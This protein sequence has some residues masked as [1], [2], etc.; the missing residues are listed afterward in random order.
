MDHEEKFDD[1]FDSDGK[2]GP[3]FDCIH[4]EGTQLFNE[5]LNRLT[6]IQVEGM[7]YNGE[8]SCESESEPIVTATECDIGVDGVG[9]GAPIHVPIKEEQLV[10]MK[11]ADLKRELKAR[12][13]PLSGNKSTLLQR[14]RETL[15]N[16][17]PVGPKPEVD[18][19]KRTEKRTKQNSTLFLL[20]KHIGS[21]WIVR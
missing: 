13:Q 5:D 17:I 7:D 9:D 1:G 18:K 12:N 6:E 21:C 8:D 16:K 19:E 20:E 10:K 15:A 11:A 2:C 4:E 3:F 14:L